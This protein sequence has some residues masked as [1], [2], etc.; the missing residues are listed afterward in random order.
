VYPGDVVTM[1]PPKAGAV[2]PAASRS[3]ILE[4]E[5]TGLFNTGMFSTT[6]SLS[7]IAGGGATLA[8]LGDAVSGIDI[9]VNPEG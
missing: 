9:R 8:G 4:I 3:S 2:N 6:T 1:V 7:T 5:V